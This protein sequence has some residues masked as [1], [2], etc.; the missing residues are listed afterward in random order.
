MDSAYNRCD[1][2]IHGFLRIVQSA[3]VS[4]AHLCNN[5]CLLQAAF[6]FSS[7]VVS[8]FCSFLSLVSHGSHILHG[9]HGASALQ[10]RHGP[11]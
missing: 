7:Y 4:L 9:P 11:G 8:G 1:N 3:Q 2:K 6:V 10:T 5:L